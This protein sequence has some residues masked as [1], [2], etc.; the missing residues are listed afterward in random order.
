MRD[1]SSRMIRLGVV[2][3]LALG[4]TGAARADDLKAAITAAD[5]RWVAAY[6]SHDAKAVAAVYTADGQILAEGS[7]P[8][9]GTAALA[10]FM[11]GVLGGGVAAV[12]LT[13]LEVVGQGRH[14]SAVGRYVMKDA[15]GKELDHGKYL[16]I[17]RLEKGVWKLHRDIFNSSVPPKK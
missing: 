1:F 14:A 5:A 4:A 8:V 15:A 7:E 2:T 17:W 3:L 16:E 13:T 11:Q 6:A 12:E 9:T 10:K